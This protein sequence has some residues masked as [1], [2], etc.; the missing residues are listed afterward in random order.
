M[1][2][3]KNFLPLFD[4][5]TIATTN[6]VEYPQESAPAYQRHKY[7]FL[8]QRVSIFTGSELY[9][10]SKRNNSV[11]QSIENTGVAFVKGA[12]ARN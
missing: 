3:I 9:I 4:Y 5:K 10:S 8:S 6:T 12:N 7:I 11:R 2:I 1:K